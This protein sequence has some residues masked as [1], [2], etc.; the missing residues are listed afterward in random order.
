MEKKITYNKLIKVVH[1]LYCDDCQTELEFSGQVYP[2]YPPRY[3]YICKNCR[4]KYSEIYKYPYSEII[5]EG[6]EE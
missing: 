4:K 3:V 2:T 1:K 6:E 5:A